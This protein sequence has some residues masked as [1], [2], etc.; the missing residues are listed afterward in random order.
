MEEPDFDK[1]EPTDPHQAFLAGWR[2]AFAHPNDRDTWTAWNEWEQ[3]DREYRGS[4]KFKAWRK[5]LYENEK[6]TAKDQ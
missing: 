6:K 5:K 3:R 2:F 1:I 4:A